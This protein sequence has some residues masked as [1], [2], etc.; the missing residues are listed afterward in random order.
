MYRIPVSVVNNLLLVD[1]H[2]RSTMLFESEEAG[3]TR[4][5]LF[6]TLVVLISGG[7]VNLNFVTH[8]IPFGRV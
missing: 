3:E 2:Y 4:V 8:E 7:M 6:I 5:N 1:Y